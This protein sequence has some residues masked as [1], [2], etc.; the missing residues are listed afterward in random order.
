M[1]SKLTLN[2]GSKKINK[3]A[4]EK[5]AFSREVPSFFEI[6][7]ILKL[8]YPAEGRQLIGLLKLR[9]KIGA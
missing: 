2:A 4:I 6:L 1:S 8:A 7:K 3:G 5:R 9:V